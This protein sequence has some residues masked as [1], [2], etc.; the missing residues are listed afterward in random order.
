VDGRLALIIAGERENVDGRGG[1]GHTRTPMTVVE[2]IV[3]IT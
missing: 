3:I 2:M 1:S